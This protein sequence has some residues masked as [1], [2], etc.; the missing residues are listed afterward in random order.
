MKT[1]NKIIILGLIPF[2]FLACSVLYSRI[3]IQSDIVNSTKRIKLNITYLKTEEKR[4]PLF[5]LNQSILKEITADKQVSYKVFDMLYLTST[6]YKLEKNVYIIIDNEAF[7]MNIINEEYDNITSISEN[8]SDVMLAD[9]TKVSVVTGYSNNN[10]KVTKYSYFLNEDIIEK[11][12]NSDSVFFRYYSG[13]SMITLKLWG[14]NLIKL[15]N[16]IEMQ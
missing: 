3:D 1:F 7:K 14:K 10:Y 8:K 6:S 9:S 11:I 2:T 5:S 16:L 15:K 13:A 12:K 4:T